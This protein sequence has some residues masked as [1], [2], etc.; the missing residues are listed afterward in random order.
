MV[1]L[2]GLHK[3]STEIK[4]KK[5]SGRQQSQKHPINYVFMVQQLDAKPFPSHTSGNKVHWSDETRG[6]YQHHAAMILGLD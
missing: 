6:L 2:T 3:S 1:T 5:Q 4:K